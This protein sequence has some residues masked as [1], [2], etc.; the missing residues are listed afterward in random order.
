MIC[1]NSLAILKIILSLTLITQTITSRIPKNFVIPSTSVNI[2]NN[3]YN[4]LKFYIGSEFDKQIEEIPVFL[5]IEYDQTIIGDSNLSGWG[6][7]CSQVPEFATNSCVLTDAKIQKGNYLKNTYSY[8]PAQAFVRFD[9]FEV[10]LSSNW[11]E[12]L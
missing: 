11:F 1:I 2:N 3:Y 12:L 8:R 6:V 4:L 10:L 7:Q 9:K 5:D